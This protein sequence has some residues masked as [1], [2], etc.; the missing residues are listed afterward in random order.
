MVLRLNDVVDYWVRRVLA[1]IILHSIRTTC[2]GKLERV[3]QLERGHHVAAISAFELR[4]QRA[5]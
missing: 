2:T 4:M 5:V 3:H 1:G